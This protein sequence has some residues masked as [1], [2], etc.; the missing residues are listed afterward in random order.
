MT[1][2]VLKPRATLEARVDM[3]GITPDRLAGLS[4]ADVEH[5][6]VPHGGRAVALAELFFVER[7]PDSVLLVEI[8]DVRLDHLGAGMTAGEIIVEGPVGAWAGLAMSG[9]VMR[10]AGDAGDFVGAELSGGRIEL[11]GNAGDH[12]G[13]ASSGSRRGL[14]GG[15]LRI[16]GSVGAR[17]GERQRGGLIVVFGDAGGGLSTDMIAGTI[18]VHG[19][20]GPH[21]GRGM[22]RG[23]VLCHKAPD[24]PAGFADTGTHDLIA[25]RLLARRVAELGEMIGNATSARRLVGDLLLGGQG[26]VLVVA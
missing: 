15:L 20:I 10:I 23:T 3:T 6:S 7:A 8:G 2:I 19:K 17:A 14:S 11:A 18:C 24:L 4:L 5:L 1:G 26:E 16:A 25:L 12:A 21:M 22:K 13:A 9:G